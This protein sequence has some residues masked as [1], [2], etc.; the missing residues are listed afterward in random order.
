[1]L[2]ISLLTLVSIIII[3][4]KYKINYNID[5]LFSIAEQF[6]QSFLKS[7]CIKIDEK[8]EKSK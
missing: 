6:K 2:I 1:M 3:I 8:D 5:A 4:K 7:R